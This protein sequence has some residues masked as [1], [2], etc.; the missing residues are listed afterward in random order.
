MATHRPDALTFYTGDDL[1]AA[2]L[3]D[4]LHA[5]DRPYKAFLTLDW[6]SNLLTQTGRVEQFFEGPLYSG[7]PY[8]EPPRSRQS[9]GGT[10]SASQEMARA[11]S[12]ARSEIDQSEREVS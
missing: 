6:A 5:L 1:T 2:E 4:L 9:P 3:A 7:E 10:G 8:P 11:I 12:A